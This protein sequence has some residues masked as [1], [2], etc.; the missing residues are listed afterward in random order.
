MSVEEKI[1]ERI[2]DLITQGVSL[3]RGN[4][5]GQIRSDDHEAACRGW[6][7][8][9]AN[10]FN[11]AC[12]NTDSSYGDQFQR[13]L[14]KQYGFAI[15][16]G[17]G[18]GTAI[19]E[20]MIEDIKR[21]LLSSVADM[22]R[23]ETFDN[24]LDHAKYYQSKSY[25]RESGVIAGV[26]FEDSIRRICEKHGITQKGENLDALISELTKNSILSQT[27]AKRARV[28]AHVRTKATHAQWDEY[29]LPDVAT[30]IEFTEELILNYV[31]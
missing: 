30:T 14:D 31:E 19:L 17:V 3:S 12:K 20:S 6:L 29:D 10:A 4:Q 25:K 24:F 16:K 18:A 22:A 8:A 26:V 11:L 23:A 9:A 15:N 1:I 2:D 13:V 28:A 21:G 5:H 27:K 7:A